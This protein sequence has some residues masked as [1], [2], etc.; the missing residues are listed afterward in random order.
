MTRF[1]FS[2][3]SVSR[4]VLAS[5]LAWPITGIL[6]SLVFSQTPKLDSEKYLS[7][8]TLAYRWVW[9]NLWVA[10]LYGGIFLGHFVFL[11]GLFLFAKLTIRRQQER[12]TVL[13]ATAMLLVG[14][15]LKAASYT[16]FMGWHWETLLL[17]SDSLGAF[18][19][20]YLTRPRASESSLVL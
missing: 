5:L 14:L 8:W 15:I 20:V 16:F 10:P 19:V 3:S 18:L 12:K 17:V 9:T 13:V 4:V 11:A 2:T 1:R 7:A 6:T